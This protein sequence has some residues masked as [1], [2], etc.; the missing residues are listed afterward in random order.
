VKQVL[1]DKR[2]APIITMAV[3]KSDK[4][5]VLHMFYCGCSVVYDPLP[6]INYL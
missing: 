1:K 3:G 6:E 5:S 2:K 4:L